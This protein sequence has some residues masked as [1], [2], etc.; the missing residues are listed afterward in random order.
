MPSQAIEVTEVTRRSAI[1]AIRSKLGGGKDISMNGVKK[2]GGLL[3][4][5]VIIIT[6]KVVNLKVIVNIQ[7]FKHIIELIDILKPHQDQPSK[8]FIKGLDKRATHP[9]D[10]NSF[11]AGLCKSRD[12][13]IK[14]F[15][16]IIVIIATANLS[17][18]RGQQDW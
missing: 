12:N 10:K 4:G 1:V 11:S 5:L 9:N 7:T 6:I 16:I 13:T 18:K 3:S 2:R 8:R 17:L 15:I 14:A